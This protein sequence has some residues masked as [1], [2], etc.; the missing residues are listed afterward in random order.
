[1]TGYVVVVDSLVPST[2]IAVTVPSTPRLVE[3]GV[4]TACCPT[5]T[6]PMWVTG[7]LATAWY[8]VPDPITTM[9]GEAEPEAADTDPPGA[10]ETEA[11]LPEI[12]L[13]RLAA[14]SAPCAPSRL[15]CAASIE[16]WSTAN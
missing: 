14:P 8:E 10:I 5:E 6:A 15:A 2:P 16:A 11:T 12:V 9:A 3:S 4:T 13:T 1:M 7:T